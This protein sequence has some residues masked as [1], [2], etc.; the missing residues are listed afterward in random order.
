MPASPGSKTNSAS[1]SSVADTQPTINGVSKEPP[2]ESSN[3]DTNAPTD[4]NIIGKRKRSALSESPIQRQTLKTASGGQKE[5]MNDEE[6]ARRQKEAISR[7]S[8][9]LLI[10]LTEYDPTPSVLTH[11]LGSIAP[12]AGS[13]SPPNKRTKLTQPL[14]DTIHER[15]SAGTY[16][17]LGALLL[18]VAT[19]CRDIINII[20]PRTNGVFSGPSNWDNANGIIARV[21]YFERLTKELVDRERRRGAHVLDLVQE[22]EQDRQIKDREATDKV[23][24]TV[25]ANIGPLFSSLPKPE[26]VSVPSVSS[27]RSTSATASPKS[28]TSTAAT[29]V[30][31]GTQIKSEEISVVTPF[32]ETLL[33]PLITTVKAVAAEKSSTPTK[34][35]TIGEAFPPAPSL[36]TLQPVKHERCV[37]GLKWGG[38]MGYGGTSTNRAVDMKIE[39]AGHWLLYSNSPAPGQSRLGVDPY[40]QGIGLPAP[41]VAAYS[42]FAPSRDESMAKVPL[43]VKNAMWWEKKGGR[44]FRKFFSEDP[45]IGHMFKDYEQPVTTDLVVG[46]SVKE[47]LEIDEKEIEKAIADFT[48]DIPVD[49][50]LL[51]GDATDLPSGDDGEEMSSDAVLTEIS[52]LLTTLQS[53]QYSR[54]ASEHVTDPSEEEYKTYNKLTDRLTFLISTLPPHVIATIDGHP[55]SE[56]SLSKKIPLSTTLP[57]FRGTLPSED[58]AK[59]PPQVQAA[60]QNAMNAAAGMSPVNAAPVAMMGGGPQSQVMRQQT[61]QQYHTPMRVQDAPHITVNS[62]PAHHSPQ[63]QVYGQYHGHQTPQTSITTPHHYPTPYNTSYGPPTPQ[64]RHSHTP[65]PQPAAMSPSLS[66]QRPPPAQTY[67]GGHT[68]NVQQAPRPAGTPTPAQGYMYQGQQVP[69]PVPRPRASVPPPQGLAAVG[70]GGGYSSGYGSPAGMSTPNRY[71][72]RTR[73]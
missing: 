9:E 17:S 57:T 71:S 37:Y 47:I 25:M 41:F 65:Q 52:S 67:Y 35:L 8:K 60:A 6:R 55:D 7:I 13:G 27:S 28:A 66:Q 31:G 64:Q 39:P 14:P 59:P 40:R 5:G 70:V 46:K 20:A 30:S 11:S 62:G 18:D 2:A 61:S 26:H 21:V 68:I 38:E 22:L 43:A 36:P 48:M 34:V 32:S 12:L 58:S 19:A 73:R 69:S 29:S 44:I 3:A 1:L 23:A 10:V 53:Q 42:S 63:P 15:L 56:L 16:K 54:F 33:P 50:R 45:E 72:Q 51:N 4:N 49:V 24:L